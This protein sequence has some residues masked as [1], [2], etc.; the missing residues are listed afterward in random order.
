MRFNPTILLGALLISTGLSAQTFREWQDPQINELNR[1]PMRTRFYT[2]NSE[3]EARS[4]HFSDSRRVVSLHGQWKFF[5]VPNA[6]EYPEDF[7]RPDYDD[8]SWR[9]MPIPGMWEL[10]GFGDPV[11]LNVGYAWRGHFTNQ[12][13]A[14]NPTPI[15]DNRVGSYRKEI[16]VP[17]DWKGDPIYLYIGSVTSNAYIWINGEFVGYTEDSKLEAEFDVTHFIRP[18]QPNLIAFR[19]FRWCDGT[20]LEDQD[21]FR[22]SGFARDTYLYTRPA[23][24]IEDVQISQDLENNYRDGVMRLSLSTVGNP[25]IQATLY[26]PDNRIVW[27]YT[28]RGE[29]GNELTVKV[30]DVHP[31]SAEIPTLYQLILKSY[32]NDKL[33]E[34]IP[35][36][37]GFRKVEMKDGLLLFNG[38]AIKFKGANRHEMD[39]ETGYVLTHERMEQ[40]VAIMKQLNMNAVR[41]CHYPDDPYFYDL[42]DKMGLYMISETNIE[43]HGMG[44]GKESLAKQPQWEKAHVERNLRHIHARGHHPSVVIWSMSNEAGD[45]PNFSRAYREIKRVDRSRPIMLERAGTGANTD[46]FA[47]MY[48]PDAEIRKYAEKN[49]SKPLILCEYAHAMGNSLGGFREYIEAFHD[50]D[51]L[52]GGFIWDFVDQ[53]LNTERDGKHFRGYG[54][55]WNDYD[56]S[57]QNFCDNGLIAP[58]RSLHPHAYEAQHGYQPIR[59]SLE[60]KGNDATLMVHNDNYFAPL[61]SI[62]IRMDYV[63]DGDLASTTHIPCPEVAAGDTARIPLTLPTP[64]RDKDVFLNV[65]YELTEPQP[66]LSKGWILSKDQLVLHTPVR[67][68]DNLSQGSTEVTL[69]KHSKGKAVFHVGRNLSV[70]FD[71]ETGMLC[72]YRVG[73]KDYLSPGTQLSP[74][75]F[76]AP[77]DNDMGAGL[78]KKWGAWS[79]AHRTLQKVAFDV[80]DGRG[81]VEAQYDMEDTTGALIH[82]S[83]VIDRDGKIIYRQQL[84]RGTAPDAPSDLFRYGMRLQMPKEFGRIE[85]FGRG[86][87]E[88]YPDRRSGCFIGKYAS[89]VADQ[90]HSYIRPQENGL[91]SDIRYWMVINDQGEG[92]GFIA[93]QPLYA[94]TLEY[95]MESLDES[96]EKRNLHSE[97]IDKDPLSNHVHI[98]WLHMGLGTIDSWGR[99]PLDKYRIPYQDYDKTL[100]IYPVSL[101]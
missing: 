26:S 7:Y 100:V 88:N 60:L 49:P 81:Y 28:T 71:T 25:M 14:D 30:P 40:D 85:Y 5:G 72:G 87:I 32:H 73:S 24:R 63:V 48:M 2:Y 76:R 41:T 17:A 99:L 56:P 69:D 15:K 12:P 64:E 39:P 46:F 33:T 53:S 62:S 55:D 34:V 93:N 22:L 86:P 101:R 89:S 44:Y 67:K 97:L 75:F 74:L 23:S 66:A 6:D 77:T 18:G 52:Q 10:N 61:R 83:Y 13:L 58:D 65:Y 84:T 21:F 79:P 51:C 91:K 47:P 3:S 38:K 37:V 95:S 27:D 94:S 29:K 20:Y 43:S 90:F 16:T 31:W 78:Q 8:S 11:Y 82:L 54:G 68:V 57:D 50:Y 92:L 19:V 36:N 45:G 96:P 4:G 35:L 9:T 42:C 59:T 98:D 70:T 1:L 80:V